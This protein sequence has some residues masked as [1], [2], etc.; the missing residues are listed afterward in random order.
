MS[1]QHGPSGANRIMKNAGVTNDMTDEEIIN[2][3]YK[4]RSNVDKY[5]SSSPA[6]TKNNLTQRFQ[7]EHKMALA[8]AN[9]ENPPAE[10]VIPPNLA[11]AS[12]DDLAKDTALTDSE[13]KQS[14]QEGYEKDTSSVGGFE[15]PDGSYPTVKRLNEPSAHRLFREEG[16]D[17]ILD[18]KK[19]N[20]KRGVDLAQ[21]KGT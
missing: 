8:K 7:A 14:F 13:F 5:F 10:E 12:V 17:T 1:V 11:A 2:R 19:E 6:S 3:C 9:V 21:N 18:I 15:D 16:T 4:E 20:I